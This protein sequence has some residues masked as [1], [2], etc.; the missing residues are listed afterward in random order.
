MSGNLQDV[1]GGFQNVVIT[2]NSEG[3]VRIFADG[4]T[5]NG[6]STLVGE[7][8]NHFSDELLGTNQDGGTSVDDGVLELIGLVTQGDL[9]NIDNPPGFKGDGVILEGGRGELGINTTQNQSGTFFTSLISQEESER[10]IA[11]LTF[12]HE[13]LENGGNVVNRDG[14][15]GH[16]QNTVELG[17]EERDTRHLGSF[18]ESDTS[19]GETYLL[20]TL[21]D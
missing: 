7:G 14:R 3:Q 4:S 6:L 12:L 21:N 20:L 1:V 16:T 15:E 2:T 11:N 19:G 8:L 17:G 13:D 9:R 18:T 5:V 10:T